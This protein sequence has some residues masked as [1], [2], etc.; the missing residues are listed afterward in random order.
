M[1]TIYTGKAVVNEAEFGDWYL[2]AS[3]KGFYYEDEEEMSIEILKG[4]ARNL[5]TEE[6]KPIEEIL[7]SDKDLEN[8]FLDYCKQYLEDK[9]DWESS[10]EY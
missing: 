9:G 1:R 7:L 10:P 5:D 2:S 6:E 4:M 8:D 3:I